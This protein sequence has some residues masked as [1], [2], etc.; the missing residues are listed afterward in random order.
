MP[1]Y[2]YIAFCLSID[3]LIINQYLPSIIYVPD[4]LLGCPGN[5]DEF[6]SSA[7]NQEEGMGNIAS[8][9]MNE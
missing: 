3:Q 5:G 8:G 4:S 9:R 1:L 6:S 7:G 2:G